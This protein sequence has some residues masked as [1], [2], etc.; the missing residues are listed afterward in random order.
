MRILIS[1]ALLC[2]TFGLKAQH[3]P[4]LSQYHWNPLML[5]PSFAGATEGSLFSLSHRNQWLQLEGAPNTQQLSW[6]TALRDNK[7]GIGA[8]VYRDQLGVTRNNGV[9]GMYSYKLD[10]DRTH[11]LSFGIAAGINFMRSY[12]S[13]VATVDAND[14]KFTTDSPLLLA[15]NFSAG[16]KLN[17]EKYFVSL[18]IPYLLTHQN[19]GNKIQVSNDFSNY[20]YMLGGGYEYEINRDITLRP[21]L[22]LKY[23]PASP[24]QA[25][26]NLSGQY[27]DMFV[28]G[29]S[30]RTKDA[31]ILLAKYW[32]N[33]QLSVGY[34]FDLTLS[35]LARYSSGTHEISLQYHM[36]FRH[37]LSNP[38]FF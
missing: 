20:N 4:I 5:N 1:I 15:P 17:G 32:V 34:S 36:K 25:D 31:L 23:H 37:N 26:I 2:L 14:P 16:V 21:S 9:Y 7:N 38:R 24:L 11:R 30:Y 10:L 28:F 35:D 18:S 19:N 22:L 12:W 6:S 29:L 33:P 27:Q 13:E 3:A 8:V